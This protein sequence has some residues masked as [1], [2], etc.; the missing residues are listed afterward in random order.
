MVRPTAQAPQPPIEL[1]LVEHWFEELR[2][3]V[4]AK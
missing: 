3:R 2:H 1:V 4:P